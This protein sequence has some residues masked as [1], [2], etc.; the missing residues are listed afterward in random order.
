MRQLTSEQMGMVLT[1][2]GRAAGEEDATEGVIESLKRRMTDLC[3]PTT[4]A[5]Q[6][7]VMHQ[8]EGGARV[9]EISEAMFKNLGMALVETRAVDRGELMIADL[10][11]M[12]ERRGR[13]KQPVVTHK[14]LNQWL[15]EQ[16]E[17]IRVDTELRAIKEREKQVSLTLEEPGEA[18]HDYVMPG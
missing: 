10:Q 4:P 14:E 9:Y 3:G 18:D 17:Y 15:H 16:T 7:Q 5:H 8:C 6:V 13:D 12:V 2:L 11:N 1:M